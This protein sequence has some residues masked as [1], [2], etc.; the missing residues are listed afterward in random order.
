MEPDHKEHFHKAVE[1]LNMEVAVHMAADC[2][3][4]GHMVAVT[5]I[6]PVAVVDIVPVVAVGIAPV[7]AE[8]AEH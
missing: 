7:V 4:A 6:A 5:D 3:A 1:R 2:I 8:I